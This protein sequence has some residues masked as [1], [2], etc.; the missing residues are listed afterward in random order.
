M[1]T[2]L[3]MSGRQCHWYDIDGEGGSMKIAGRRLIVRQ[4]RS[5]HEQVVAVL[6]QLE[7]AAEDMVEDE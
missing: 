2:I 5:G 6:E 3:K 4:S 7:L 1:Q